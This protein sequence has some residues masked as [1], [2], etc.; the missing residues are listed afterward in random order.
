MEKTTLTQEDFKNLI[1]FMGR[2]QMN[3]N[4]APTF[5]VLQQKIMKMYKEGDEPV[6]AMKG[7]FVGASV[8]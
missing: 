1:L 5:A 7:I 8:N 2:A 3:G 4:E 6:Q